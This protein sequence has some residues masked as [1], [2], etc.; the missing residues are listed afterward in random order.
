MTLHDRMIGEPAQYLV[1]TGVCERT[2][3]GSMNANKCVNK[4]VYVFNQRVA[5]HDL[6]SVVLVGLARSQTDKWNIFK[7]DRPR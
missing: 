4:N 1:S 2:A 6:F 7:S 3:D 5:T